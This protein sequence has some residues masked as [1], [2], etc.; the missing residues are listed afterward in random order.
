MYVY[1]KQTVYI[2]THIHIHIPGSRR[3]KSEPEM[4][5]RSSGCRT[6]IIVL[7]LTLLG[8]HY[9]CLTLLVY[10]RPRLLYAC[11]V[12]SRITI[13]CYMICFVVLFT[14]LDLCVSSLC[15]GYANTLCIASILTDD[16][17]RTAALV[18][19]Y[20]Y[21]YHLLLFCCSPN[22]ISNSPSDQAHSATNFGKGYIPSCPRAAAL[23]SLY[24][25]VSS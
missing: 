6:C 19:L 21:W 12:V 8:W 2:Y 18:L 5:C 3:S 4:L 25:I 14:L 24:Y 1:D 9:T 7:L 16:P 10:R 11:F 17:R 20:C 15:R 13:I 22:C 23:A